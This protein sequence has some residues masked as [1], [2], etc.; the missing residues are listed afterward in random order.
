MRF[1]NILGNIKVSY[2]LVGTFL[3]VACLSGVVGIYAV[4]QID[5][6]NKTITEI[7]EINVEQA[8]W[9]MET[10]I[11]IEA[12]Q[13]SIHAAMLGEEEAIEKFQEADKVM[14]E[15]FSNL[16]GLL[17]GTTK[18][19]SVSNL[20]SSYTSFVA[21]T[22]GS[23][24]VF[25]SMEDYQQAL[26]EMES[27][28]RR[29]DELQDELDSKL[30]LLE[31]VV[32]HYAEHNST[33][34]EPNATLI[35]NAMELNLLVWRCGDRARMY[36]ATTLEDSAEANVERTTLR[37]EY[38]DD[39]SMIAESSFVLSGLEKDFTDLLNEADTNF[40]QA[41]SAGQSNSTTLTILGNVR[42]MF[43]FNDA[44][45][46]ESFADAIR[47]QEDG[48]FVAQDRL[49]SAWVAADNAMEIA[50]GLALALLDDFEALELWVGEQLDLAKAGAKQIYTDAFGLVLTIAFLAIATGTIVGLVLSR[51][52]T[53]PLSEIVKSSSEVAQGKL[54]VDLS[55]ID[56]E[57]KDE[58]GKLGKT[59]GTMVEKIIG[60]MVSLIKAAR[61][62][63][64]QLLTSSEEFASSSEE[65]NA[66]SE[67]ISSVIQQMNRGAQQQ[68]EQ[69]NDTV[70]NVQE[71]SDMSVK[72]I[73]DIQ[74]T[75]E[76]I[77]DVAS[78][79]NMLSLNAQI[80]AARAGDFGKS[81]MVVADNVRRLAED[82]KSSTGSIQE[83]VDDIQHQI[84]TNVD[85][86]AKSV[87][88]VAAV[89]EETAASSEEASAATEE[90]TATMEEMSAAAQELAQLA[91]ELTS[92]ISS[93]NIDTGEVASPAV[94]KVDTEKK[95][96]DVEHV[97][98][99]Q[100]L[101]IPLVKRLHKEDNEPGTEGKEVEFGKRDRKK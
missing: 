73:Q 32:A 101:V 59:F 28:F 46:Y 23:S 68:A 55:A 60:D 4:G 83:L 19:S 31:Q 44:T 51:S 42:E 45:T 87:D 35:D 12:Q 8:D 9:S 82:T 34:F 98:Q 100:K 7:T 33:P 97:E 16:T 62:A 52:I 86:I 56:R 24:G 92:S 89:A 13:V 99:S 18:E 67:E 50:D 66:S 3:V 84:S 25:K 78:Q 61:V 69:I 21:A 58:I 38:A 36:L 39:A 10:I 30:S 79:T 11:A 77:S 22:T 6:L 85:K 95:R 14:E 5:T 37:Q 47:C 43:V 17:A 26:S 1:L 74:N 81:F 54:S 70:T 94:A 53:K 49:V 15:G 40:A 76:L 64:E 57:R 93:F 96:D 27:Q 20:Q 80:E 63:A 48:V 90:Q 2:K 75:V 65:L 88:S 71:L 41:L 29:I 91:E 72:I